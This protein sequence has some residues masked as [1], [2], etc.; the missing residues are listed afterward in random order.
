MR[1]RPICQ[2]SQRG[3]PQASLFFF[4]V[5]SAGK[6]RTPAHNRRGC[7]WK[8][9]RPQRIELLGLDLFRWRSKRSLYGRQTDDRWF[10]GQSAVNGHKFYESVDRCWSETE[11]PRSLR[12]HFSRDIKAV[13]IG[14]AARRGRNGKTFVR[15]G[16]WETTRREIQ[17]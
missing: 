6:Q 1:M 11:P 12:W 16:W 3:V 10:Y 2:G 7:F 13:A 14:T 4:I 15:A 5:S 9:C 8:I 17:R